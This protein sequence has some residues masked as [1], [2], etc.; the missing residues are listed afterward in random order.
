MIYLRSG[1]QNIGFVNL[2]G[3]ST[4]V[5]VGTTAEPI[6]FGSTTSVD[7]FMPL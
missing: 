5:G 3:V 6:A 2:V 1:T 7:A 4:V